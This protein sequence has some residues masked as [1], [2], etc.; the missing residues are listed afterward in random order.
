MSI[1]SM[2]SRAARRVVPQQ[3]PPADHAAAVQVQAAPDGARRGSTLSVSRPTRG[4][5]SGARDITVTSQSTDQAILEVRDEDSGTVTQALAI[6]MTYIPTEIL[7]LYVPVLAA[8]GASPTSKQGS[9]YIAFYSFL[10]ATPLVVWL[11]TAARLRSQGHLDRI[12]QFKYLPVWEM[13]AATTAFIAWALAL[14]NQLFGDY[15]NSA[16]AGLLVPASATALG[17]LE[18]VFGPLKKQGKPTPVKDPAAGG[19]SDSAPTAD[20][21]SDSSAA[22]RRHSP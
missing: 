14:P 3:N 2:A 9:E 18:P 1:S 22:T 5:L 10:V 15:T 19:D 13:F 11:M 17:L 4:S 16:I 20:E 12:L 7:T 21:H 8:L 6:V